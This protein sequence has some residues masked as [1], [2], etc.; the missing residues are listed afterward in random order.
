MH[1]ARFC[2]N[3]K[4]TITALFHKGPGIFNEKIRIEANRNG[5]I[6]RNLIFF[7]FL[8]DFLQLKDLNPVLERITTEVSRP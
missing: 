1:R 3:E 5:R 4:G 7:L 8:I 2:D 6:R